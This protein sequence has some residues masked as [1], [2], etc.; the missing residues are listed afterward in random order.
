MYGKHSNLDWG[1][2][3]SQA[4]EIGNFSV[5]DKEDADCWDSCALGERER[6]LL[7]PH[8]TLRQIPKYRKL[9]M[10]FTH[11]VENDDFD[12]IRK[13]YNAI[14][15]IENAEWKTTSDD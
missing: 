4:E 6:L 12:W 10:D 3:I 2:R 15:E 9:G 11:A 1:E 5:E 13:I 8:G 7:L 14:Q